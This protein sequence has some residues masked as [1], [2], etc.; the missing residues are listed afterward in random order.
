MSQ[1]Q[2]E[3]GTGLLDWQLLRRSLLELV[4]KSA[5]SFMKVLTGHRVNYWLDSVCIDQTSSQDKAYGIPR[6]D[7]IYSE[8]Y[9]FVIEGYRSWVSSGNGKVPAM[10]L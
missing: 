2:R 4:G 1:W 3:R 7:D 5:S 10:L 6:M 9:G 8:V